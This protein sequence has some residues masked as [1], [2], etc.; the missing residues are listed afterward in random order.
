MAMAVQDGG[1]AAMGGLRG[2]VA[3]RWSWAVVLVPLAV[4]G[5]CSQRA[6]VGGTVTLDGRP[7]GG[8]VVTFC[9]AADG[10]S[11]YAAIGSD[12]RYAVQ[13]GSRAGLPPGDY[14][15]TVAANVPPAEGSQPGPGQFSDGITPLATPQIYADRE[16]SP[17]RATL[18][19]G[20]QELRLELTSQ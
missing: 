9:P 4:A 19:S 6:E 18:V 7:L 3:P 13:V 12:G 11:G 14:V 17:L 16:Q 15:V 5:G 2:I 8:G 20:S 10:P 1:R